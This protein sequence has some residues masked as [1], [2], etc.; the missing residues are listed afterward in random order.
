MSLEAIFKFCFVFF[1]KKPFFFGH[2]KGLIASDFD[3]SDTILHDFSR[4]SR[5]WPQNSGFV[6]LGVFLSFLRLLGV[7]SALFFELRLFRSVRL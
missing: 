3:E 1:S 7:F 5:I 6:D 4:R 2:E